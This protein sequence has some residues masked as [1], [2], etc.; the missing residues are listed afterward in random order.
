MRLK[1]IT[2]LASL[3]AALFL[4]DG[5]STS[6]AQSAKLQTAQRPPY[7]AGVPLE[8]QVIAEGFKESPQPEIQFNQPEGASLNLVGV[9]PSVSSSIQIINGR[10][11]Q[12]RSVIYNYRL[13]F[14][15][16]K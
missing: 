9:S 1:Y 13:N 10:M 3:W 11:T 12:S 6:W 4:V 7:Y 15:A 14:L 8:L 5:L 2:F 16:S